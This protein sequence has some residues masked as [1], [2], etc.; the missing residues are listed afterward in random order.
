MVPPDVPS[1]AGRRFGPPLPGDPDGPPWPTLQDLDR[2]L[3]RILAALEA[4]AYPPVLVK[5]VELGPVE[6]RVNGEILRG[7]STEDGD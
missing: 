3:D 2:K 4:L 1:P 7:A 5:G 6:I